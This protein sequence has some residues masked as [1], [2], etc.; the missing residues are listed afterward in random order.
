M[1]VAGVL[2]LSACGSHNNASGGGTGTSAP[3]VK[4]T[5]GGKPDLKASGSTAQKNAMTEFVKAFANAC[6][7]QSLDYTADDSSA[8][9][10]EFLDNKNDFGGSDS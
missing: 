7:G 5:C 8:G 10:N 9:I 3:P 1:L 6:P 2:I 4:V